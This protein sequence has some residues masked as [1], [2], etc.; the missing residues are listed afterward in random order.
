LG[1]AIEGFEEA[2]DLA[3]DAKLAEDASRA[4]AVVRGEVARRRMRAGQP[5]AVDAGPSL[6]RAVAGLLAE[7]TW[8]I[9]SVVAS[10]SLTLGLFARWLSQGPKARVGGGVLAGVAAPLLAVAVAMTMAARHDRSNL[11]EAIVVAP[12]ARAIDSRGIAVAGGATL[13]EGARVEIV[14]ERSGATRVRSGPLEAWVST[15][16]LR[17][18]ARPE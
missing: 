11:R 17:E 6:A 10:V 15:G 2:R 13:P 14:G 12:S 3:R 7:D 5:A 8:A 4:L 9:L 16:L 1:R 18:I